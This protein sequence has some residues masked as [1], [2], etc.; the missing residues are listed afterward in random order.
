MYR[1]RQ[2]KKAKVKRICVWCGEEILVGDPY[3][4]RSYTFDGDFTTDGLH[5]E[6]LDA[7]HDAPD[8]WWLREYGFSPHEH[9]RGTNEA[10]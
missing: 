10:N 6:C 5:H 2:V 9:K 3:V 1:E 7:M 4:Y 8:Q